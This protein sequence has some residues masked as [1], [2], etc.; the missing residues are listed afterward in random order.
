M[1][2]ITSLAFIVSDGWL[3][4]YRTTPPSSIYSWSIG[5]ILEHEFFCLGHLGCAGSKGKKV[6][7][8]NSEQ[9]LRVVFSTFW[10]QKKILKKFQKHFSNRIE[11]LHK[12]DF[13]KKKFFLLKKLKKLEKIGYHPNFNFECNTENG[14]KESLSIALGVEHLDLR[15]LFRTL[16]P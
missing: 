4:F 3:H 8:R 7:L 5:H 10:G 11:K 6:D 16:M 9:L 12:I 13:I 1:S 14:S 2:S 15:I